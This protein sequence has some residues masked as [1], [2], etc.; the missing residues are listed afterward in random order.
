MLVYFFGFF[1]IS[2]GIDYNRSTLE[3]ALSSWNKE[4][5]MEHGVMFPFLIAAMLYSK[6]KDILKIYQQPDFFGGRWL[7]LLAVVVA[8][9]FFMIAYRTIQPRISMGALPILLSGCVCY[10]WGLR[11]AIVTAFPLFFFW[12]AIPLPSFQQATVGLQH[13]STWL[14]QSLSGFV[15]VETVVKGTEISAADGSWSNLSVAGGCSGIRSLMALLMISGAYSYLTRMA[16]WKKVLLL[17]SAVPIAVLANS[18]RIGSICAMAEYHD[19]TFATGTWH[20]W[21]GLFLFF[22]FSLF[23][24]ITLH[25]VLETKKSPLAFLFKKSKKRVIKTQVGS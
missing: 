9:L 15:G 4:T 1:E 14:A 19:T 22:P 7:G 12:L 18:V 20:D 10:L 11:V 6:R 17:L 24:L 5:D 21:S 16:L 23:L 3:W 8:C 25:S 13:I 2:R